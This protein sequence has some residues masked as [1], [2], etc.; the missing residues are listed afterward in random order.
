MST[1]DYLK[2]THMPPRQVRIGDE[3]FE[4][5]AALEAMGGGLKDGG[6]E[7]ALNLRNYIA[8]FVREPGA[9]ALKR[10]PAEKRDWIVKR[11]AEL[12]K[13]AAEKAKAR[14]GRARKKA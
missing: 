2:E 1:P 9:A 6:T 4:F 14:T 13:E 10:P 11:G 3:W 8:W 5:Q 12:K 7:R